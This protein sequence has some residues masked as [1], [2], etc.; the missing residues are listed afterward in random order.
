ML[1]FDLTLDATSCAAGGTVQFYVTPPGGSVTAM[2]PLQSLPSTPPGN[3]CIVT[4]STA[5]LIPGSNAIYAVYSGA[6]SVG[7]GTSNTVTQQVNE[8]GTQVTLSVRY[9]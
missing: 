2:G 6:G 7:G 9:P 1:N 5:T 4:L 3:S 8:V